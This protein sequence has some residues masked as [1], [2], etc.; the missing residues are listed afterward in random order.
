MSTEALP[1]LSIKEVSDYFSKAE[2][3]TR[4][5]FPKI[6][7]NQGDFYNK[8]INFVLDDSYMQ[9]HLHP[10]DE[11]IEKMYLLKGSFALIQFDVKGKITNTTI[12][13]KG[14][15]ESINVPAF[16]WHTYVMLTKEVIV[17]ETMEGVYEPSTW[18]VMAQW[19]PVENTQEAVE[20]LNFLKSKI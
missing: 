15:R 12:L 16:R 19:A 11:K 6:L 2:Q 14:A 7:H 5:R 13:E 8:V 3:S 20:Y 18:K 4:K 10:G 1:Q 17:Y 9:P